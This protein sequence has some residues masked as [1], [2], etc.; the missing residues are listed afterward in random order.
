[1]EDNLS[2]A[3]IAEKTGFGSATYM[4]RVFK[5]KLGITPGKY[6]QKQD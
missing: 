3:E 6:K 1:M 2:I 5:Q 4:T